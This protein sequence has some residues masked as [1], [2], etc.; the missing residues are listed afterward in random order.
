MYVSCRIHGS[1]VPRT[2]FVILLLHEHIII[3][4]VA[5]PCLYRC[6]VIAIVLFIGHTRAAFDFSFGGR[7]LSFLF[8][9]RCE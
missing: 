5:S 4:N 1:L 2:V 6:S 8:S 7:A 3:V 9:L